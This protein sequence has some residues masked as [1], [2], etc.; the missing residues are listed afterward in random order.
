M[1][2][3]ILVLCAAAVDWQHPAGMIAESTIAEAK[4]KIETH[5]WAKTVFEQQERAVEK[6]TKPDLETL[7]AAFPTTR[8]NVYHNFSCPDDRSRLTFH[9]MEPDSYTCPSC[10]K[11]FPR[12]TV[13]TVY[14]SDNRYHG[15]MYDGWKCMFFQHAAIASVELAAMGRMTDNPA[16][17]DRA[18][19]LL[20]L[21]TKTIEGITTTEDKDPQMRR[22]FTYH[23]EGDNKILFDL[24]QTFELLRDNL[25]EKE[26]AWVKTSLLDRLLNDIMLEPIYTYD[27]NNVFQWHRTIVQ[28]A[29]ALEREDLIDW[30]FGYGAFSKENSPEHRSMNRMLAKNFKPDGAYWGLCSGYHLYPLFHI[31]EFAVLSKHL[32]QMDPKRFPAKQYDFTRAESAGGTT[33]RNALHWFMSMA[34]PDRNMPT[35]GDSTKPEGSMMDYFVT[36]EVGYKHYDL[37]AVGDYE[38]MRQGNRNWFGLLHGAPEIKKHDL[39]FKSAHL[40]S[41]WVSLRNEWQDNQSWV[42]LNA[43]QVGSGHQHADRLNLLWYSHGKKLLHEKATP[44]NEEVTRW[45]G[46]YSQSHNTV[47]V[48]KESF[49][50]G[51]ELKEEQAPEVSHFFSNDWLQYAELRGDKLYEST[52]KYR[53]FVLLIE[54]I[55]VDCFTVEGGTPHDWTAQLTGPPVLSLPLTDAPFEPKDWLYNGTEKIQSTQTDG[56]WEATWKADDVQARLTMLGAPETTVYT[57]ETFPH[58]NAVITEAKPP[59]NTLCVRRETDAP[60][61]VL[62]DAWKDTPNLK[63][64]QPGKT[65]NALTLETNAHTYHITFGAGTH[66]FQDGWTSKTKSIM[67]IRR[68]TD[69]AFMVEATKPTIAYQTIGGENIA[70]E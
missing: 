70:T 12:E 14:K 62:W 13:S 67:T 32:S 24:A 21:F 54:D 46:R 6:W 37:K 63:K 16:Y 33:I 2:S 49:E 4:E 50:E 22:V 29:L 47:T 57:L 30:S 45:L 43:L 27:H 9:P 1:T 5:D 39:P 35:I 66:R 23:R 15:T 53:R 3:L 61:I 69:P 20:L 31:C 10:E 11:S 55:V 44:Y 48:G 26:Q 65:P 7:R 58:D 25:S 41:G 59:T 36:A 17:T 19:D 8:G 42:G 34:M 68:D 51:G 38:K 56:V 18:R 40:S 60:F 64:V 52:S 28:T